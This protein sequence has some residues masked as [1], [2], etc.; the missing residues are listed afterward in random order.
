MHKKREQV[1]L[2]SEKQLYHYQLVSVHQVTFEGGHVTQYGRQIGSVRS[3][4]IAFCHHHD[5]FSFLPVSD[6]LAMALVDFYRHSSL[7]NLRP[8]DQN[9]PSGFL[10]G[11]TTHIVEDGDPAD[12]LEDH[13]VFIG[14]EDFMKFILHIPSDWRAQWGPVV[15][16]VKRDPAFM[17]HYLEYRIRHK[18]RCAEPEESHYE[19]LLLMNDATLRTAFPAILGRDSASTP[20]LLTQLVHIVDDDGSSDRV[21]ED[22]SSIP[23][24]IVEGRVTRIP[25]IY[26]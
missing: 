11:S 19:S 4:L 17:K 6:N 12:D 20:L 2:S 16:S 22:G 10:T 18:K 26:S 24:L 25:R 15:R 8:H 5:A 21:L 7:F 13:S 1:S 9:P 14:I 23:Q 3:G